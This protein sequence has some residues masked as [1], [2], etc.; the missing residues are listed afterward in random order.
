MLARHSRICSKSNAFPANKNFVNCDGSPG[1]L[2]T[3]MKVVIVVI[4]VSLL[5]VGCFA[6]SD[7]TQRAWNQPVE[8]FRIVGNIYYVGASDI[9]S[10]LI[11]SPKGHILLDG[12]FVET[13]PQIRENIRKLG[14]KEKDVKILINSHSHYDHAAGLAELKRATEA[15]LV[16]SKA[17]G[18]QIA[19]GGKGDLMWGDE[20]PFPP[21]Q[22][23][24]IIADGD[25]V[26]VGEAVMTA[27]ITPGHTKG[28]TTWTMQANENGKRYDVVFVCS[29]S[30]PG[31]KLVNNPK[32]PDIVKDYRYTFTELKSFPCDVML[33]SH[34][35][36]FHLTEKRVA[37]K[38]HPAANP[39]VKP[40]DYRDYLE[41]SEA[42]FEKELKRQQQ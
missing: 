26:Q 18:A 40:Q 25:T 27:H 8:P 24:R 4:A 3:R 2:P 34:G 17:D 37:L 42:E 11:T 38:T 35:Q 32:Y 12:G 1:N 30:A 33:A 28:C 21:A 9:T 23:D 39:F 31:Y 22:P 41:R 13:A 16:V 5:C 14:F 36:F 19:R 6:Q 20:H 29:T 7:P 10:F 15:K